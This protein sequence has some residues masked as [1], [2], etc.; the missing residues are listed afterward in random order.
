LFPEDIFSAG[1]PEVEVSSKWW[2]LHTRPRAEKALARKFL[3]RSIPFFL[4]LYERRW[5]S[6]GRAF[7][8]HVPLFPSYLF[9]N[10]NAETRLAALE[11]N[12]VVRVLT[13]E[14][15]KEMHHDLQRVY[16]LI[17]SGNALSPESRLVPGTR[18]E[19]TSGALAGVEGKVLRSGRQ[20]KFFVEVQFLQRGVSLEIDSWMIRPLEGHLARGSVAACR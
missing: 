15:Q 8:S 5:R 7:C 13:V 10:G 19:I 16:Q 14:D 4:P 1:R 3:D 6:R 12:L 18:V 20:L 9:L 2:V 11:T 17:T